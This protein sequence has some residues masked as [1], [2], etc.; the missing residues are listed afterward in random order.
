MR[1]AIRISV[2]VIVAVATLATATAQPQIT[3]NGVLNAAST[4]LIGFP[5]SSIAQGSIF[6]IYG[7]GLGPTS[8]P[9]LAYPLQ[10]TLGGVSVQITSGNLTLGALPIF[11]GPNQ[12][13]AVLPG[14]TPTGSATV[15]VTYNG[16]TSNAAAFQVITSSF[17]IFTVGA[18]GFGAGVITGA[19][20]QLYSLNSP[21]HPGDAATIWGTGIG[22]S[23]GD[24]GSAPPQQID[25]PNLSLSVYIGTQPVT[26][27]YRGRS[28]FTGEDQINFVMPAGITGCYVPVAVEIGNVVSNFVTMPVAPTGLPCPD[29]AMAAPP[30]ITGNVALSRSTNTGFPIA[31]GSI[32]INGTTDF[33]GAWF[34]YP[35]PFALLDPVANLLPLLPTGTCGGGISFVYFFDILG[36]TFDAGP[37]VTVTGPNGSEQIPLALEGFLYAAQL[38]GGSGATAEPLFLDPGAYTVSAPGGTEAQP[39]PNV[40]PFSQ[41]FSILPFTWTN[42]SDITTVDRSASLDVTWTGGDPNSTVQIIGA[43]NGTG[44][45]CNANT[46]DQH[47]TIPAFTLLSLPGSSGGA[48][49]ISTTSTTPFTAAGITSGTISST[50]AIQQNVTYQ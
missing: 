21:A 8:S 16:E 22:A 12:I 44:F 48:L 15:T 39:F 34:G 14:G 13:N 45:E 41:T 30:V 10:T 50:V 20:N 38:G 24:D 27:T 47:F 7:S 42:R 36:N 43:V 40:G 6:S 17:G 29:P 31:N 23:P 4:A 19:N 32:D 37:A 46:S 18:T 2:F 5:N 25:M 9:T 3:S 26:V 11:V 28:G 35:V 33:G 49:G 1:K